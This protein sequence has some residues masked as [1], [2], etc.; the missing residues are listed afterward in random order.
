MNDSPDEGR[1]LEQLKEVTRMK[2]HLKNKWKQVH[3]LYK[4]KQKE[5]L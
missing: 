4:S 1:D 5:K 2:E 3:A